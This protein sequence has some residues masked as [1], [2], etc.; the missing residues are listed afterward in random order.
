MYWKSWLSAIL[1]LQIHHFRWLRW[2]SLDAWT[3][4]IQINGKTVPHKIFL[5]IYFYFQNKNLKMSYYWRQTTQYLKKAANIQFAE[6][7]KT[8]LDF[9]NCGTY[10]APEIWRNF[11]LCTFYKA[12]PLKFKSAATDCLLIRQLFWMTLQIVN[13][14]H[15]KCNL[16]GRTFQFFQA[17][18][19]MENGKPFHLCDS[20]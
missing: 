17:R 3:S 7:T 4:I 5:K 10:F 14:T 16:S 20:F 1:V 8:N 19:K 13:S 15:S 12:E 6:Q 9:N 2:V 18:Y 11:L